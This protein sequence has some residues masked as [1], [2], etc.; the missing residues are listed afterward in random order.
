MAHGGAR[1]GAG[2]KSDADIQA[3]RAL[4]DAAVSPDDWRSIFETLAI[5][6]I[7]GNERCAELLMKYKFGLPTQPL[8][9]EQVSET[10]LTLDL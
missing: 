7:Q 2:R 5:K 1:P 10:W 3:A 6:A 4:I 9:V 8:D